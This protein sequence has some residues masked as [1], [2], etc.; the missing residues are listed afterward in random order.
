[1]PETFCGIGSTD[2]TNYECMR[3]GIGI[4]SRVKLKGRP[5]KYEKET[6]SKVY[7]G[8]RARAPRGKRKGDLYTCFKKGFLIGKNLQWERKGYKYDGDEYDFVNMK[9]LGDYLLPTVVAL[10]LFAFFIFIMGKGILI[11]LI[12]SIISVLSFYYLINCI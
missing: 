12:I 9:S 8:E 10:A 2:G 5:P 6:Y 11:S 4:G 7:C 1:M 3:K